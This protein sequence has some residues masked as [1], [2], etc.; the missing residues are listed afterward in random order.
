MQEITV[1]GGGL[2]GLVA[3]I[4]AAEAGVGVRL[5]EQKRHLGGRAR[6]TETPFRA[7]WGPHVI[8]SDGPLLRW[9]DERGLARPATRAP[10]TAKFLFRI[11]GRAR[12]VPPASMIRALL[13]LRRR[14]APV[15]MTFTEWASGLVGEEHARRLAAFIGVAT[16]DHDPGRLSAA[17]VNERLTR[18]TTVPPTVRYMPGGWATMIERLAE[19]AH[20][21]G[22]RIE[23]DAKVDA[24]PEGPVI[25]ALPLDTARTMTG[26][27]GLVATGTRTTLLDVGVQQSRRVPFIV[28]DLDAPGWAETY[29]IPDQSL[30]P[31]GHHLIQAQA[32]LRPG[33]SLEEGVIRLEE[34]L[35]IG[36]TNWRQNEVW[37]RRARVDNE[38]G[39][40]DLPGQTW[41]DRPAI[42]RGDGVF[43][44]GDMVAAPGLLSEVSHESALRAVAAITRS[45]HRSVLASGRS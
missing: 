11:D 29:S 37:R 32:G 13:C 31:T 7:N 8:Y 16:F 26:D 27:P 6:T 18:T 4:T 1:V 25:L 2:G 9:L 24:L 43:V 21:L 41:R 15:D 34:L 28:S 3:A 22:V 23:T 12:R 19:R 5:M 10:L 35:D 17:F 30:A 39:A 36:Y 38:S 42:D 20:S 45:H 44:V 33:D 40:L 14:A